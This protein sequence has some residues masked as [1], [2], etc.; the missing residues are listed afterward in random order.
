MIHSSSSV[1][2]TRKVFAFAEIRRVSTDTVLA[3][4]TV[5]FTWQQT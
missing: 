5:E 3:G 2:E 1:V 4:F